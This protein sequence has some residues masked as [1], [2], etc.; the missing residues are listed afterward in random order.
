MRKLR[1]EAY[2]IQSEEIESYCRQRN[3]LKVDVLPGDVAEAALFLAS[4]RSGKTTGTILPVDGGV[5]EAF[6]R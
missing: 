3:L 1:T 5:K 4:D 6:P 2:G